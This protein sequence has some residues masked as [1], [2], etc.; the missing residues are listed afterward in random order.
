MQL[1]FIII[2]I[3]IYH[4]TIPV[5]K[6]CLQVAGYRQPATGESQPRMS[7]TPSTSAL[8]ARS[9][10][11][12]AGG[13]VWVDSQPDC[14]TD[15]VSVLPTQ[16]Y[17]TSGIYGYMDEHKKAMIQQWVEGQSRWANFHVYFIMHTINCTQSSGNRKVHLSCCNIIIEHCHCMM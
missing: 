3:V 1:Y 5:N 2:Y 6:Y 17:D 4:N 16:Q 8:S 7:L 13:E 10:G 11:S 15:L 14:D 9:R 12:V